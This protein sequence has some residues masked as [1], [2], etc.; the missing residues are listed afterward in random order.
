MCVGTHD[1]V[2]DSVDD[3]IF[4][5]GVEVNMLGR[6]EEMIKRTSLG[7]G[8]GSGESEGDGEEGRETE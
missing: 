7:V 6:R 4:E 2:D 5:L 1:E 8:D 3:G